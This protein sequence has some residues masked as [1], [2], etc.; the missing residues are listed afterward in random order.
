MHPN[1]CHHPTTRNRQAAP[2]W[3]AADVDRN[4][5]TGKVPRPPLS[6]Y[7]CGYPQTKVF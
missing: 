7:R 1:E 6:K 5:E 4:R 2:M 3:R